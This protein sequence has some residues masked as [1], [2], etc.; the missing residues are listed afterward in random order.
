MTAE[1]IDVDVR[2]VV[3][4]KNTVGE[5]PVWAADEQALYWV[6]ILEPAVHRWTP[7]RG[8]R[9]RWPVPA[10]VGSIGLREG[11]HRQKTMRARSDVAESG[12]ERFG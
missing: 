11:G 2:C 8:E 5:S 4:A 7:A 3:D 1:R 10:A 12:L 6:D 9:R